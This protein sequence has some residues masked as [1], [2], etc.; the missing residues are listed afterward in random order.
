MIAVLKLCKKTFRPMSFIDNFENTPF[1]LFFLLSNI[2]LIFH[3]LFYFAYFLFTNLI[4]VTMFSILNKKQIF[5][6]IY[7]RKT[8]FP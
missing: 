6:L 1:L 5:Y 8:S 3:L 7:L 2:Y 4:L